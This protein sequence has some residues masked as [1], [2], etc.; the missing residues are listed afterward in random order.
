MQKKMESYLKVVLMYEFFTFF[1]IK[2]FIQPML[3]EGFAADLM[4]IIEDFLCSLFTEQTA[5]VKQFVNILTV[6][7]L[8]ILKFG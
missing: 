8:E 3:Y 5:R 4:Y 2:L 7:F 1:Y 6:N